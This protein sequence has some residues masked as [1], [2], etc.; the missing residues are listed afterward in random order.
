M[1]LP[2]FNNTEEISEFLSDNN[3]GL[4]YSNKFKKG[5]KVITLR[6]DYNDSAKVCAIVL[7]LA[8]TDVDVV[9]SLSIIAKSA[10]FS[11]GDVK[12]FP[13]LK[14]VVSANLSTFDDF[15]KEQAAGPG[16]G[17]IPNPFDNESDAPYMK[18]GVIVGI[19][20]GVIFLI[21]MIA[22]FAYIGNMETDI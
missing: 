6:E 4:A 15:H 9:R 21:S 8:D 2:I 10:A 20:I 12:K 3:I 19:V 14:G 11:Y 1:K 13:E 22:L 17:K 7:G 16:I 5:A 18:A